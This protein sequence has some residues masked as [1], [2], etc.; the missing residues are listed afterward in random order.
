MEDNF[1]KRKKIISVLLALFMVLLLTETPVFS[2]TAGISGFLRNN[3]SYTNY[4][5]DGDGKKDKI[6]LKESKQNGY[7]FTAY[8]MVNGK[9]VYTLANKSSDYEN[10]FYQIITL[11]NGKR[12]IYAGLE[13]PNSGISKNKIL[14][15]KNGKMKLVTNITD[16]MKNYQGASFISNYPEKGIQIKGNDIIIKYMS[17][18]RTTGYRKFIITLKYKN[19]NLVRSYSGDLEYENKCYHAKKNIKTYEKPGSEKVSYT[20]KAGEGSYIEKYYLKGGKLYL[21]VRDTRGRIGWI[22]GLTRTQT[23]GLSG[24]PLFVEGWYAS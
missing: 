20:L 9:R 1:M 5:L 23:K 12:F 17:M 11:Q 15:Y 3:R 7:K 14:V 19:G 10:A 16:L 8:F 24:S 13:G 6:L 22:K 18:N 2:A 21:R 4:D